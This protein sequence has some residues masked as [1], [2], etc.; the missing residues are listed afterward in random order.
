MRKK[1]EKRKTTNQEDMKKVKEVI[2]EKESESWIN[3]QSV[4]SGE[5]DWAGGETDEAGKG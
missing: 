5:E 1:T 3:L 4:D 2:F